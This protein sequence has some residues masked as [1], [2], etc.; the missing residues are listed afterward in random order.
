MHP[1]L[2]LALWL[3]ICATYFGFAAVQGI[4]LGRLRS[5]MGSI[6][7]TTAAAAVYLPASLLVLQYEGWPLG[8]RVI[9]LALGLGVLVLAAARPIWIGN[10]WRRPVALRYLA[11]A[12]GFSALAEVGLAWA[13]A[14]AAA[15]FVGMAAGLAGLASLRSSLRL[16]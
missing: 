12:M 15:A 8:L 10:W 1:L 5:G 3:G 16:P 2:Q 7:A 14:S 9:P 4:L 11:A 13:S 6:V